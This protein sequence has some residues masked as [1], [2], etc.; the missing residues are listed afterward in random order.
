MR[1]TKIGTRLVVLFLI[2]LF[3]LGLVAAEQTHASAGF[4]SSTTST[5]RK[6]HDIFNMQAVQLGVGEFNNRDFGNTGLNI[7]TS[8]GGRYGLIG[9]GALSVNTD[10][11]SIR[12]N[13]LSLFVGYRTMYR[14]LKL[15]SSL[16]YQLGSRQSY[17]R[18]VL[19]FGPAAD[20]FVSKKILGVNGIGI[21]LSI[22]AH[23]KEQA[24]TTYLVWEIANYR[25]G[26]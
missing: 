19:Y 11:N 13:Q 26:R 10:T 18:E 20:V 14:G 22:G 2:H 5:S 7:S 17:R 25:S 24:A 15:E 4:V 8:L 6:S 21:G 23:G 12:E 9:R 16:G 1:G 3:P